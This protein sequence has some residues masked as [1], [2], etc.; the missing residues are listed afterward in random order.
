VNYRE[1]A[2][3]VVRTVLNIAD[4]T[5]AEIVETERAFREAAAEALNLPFAIRGVWPDGRRGAEPL[6][7]VGDAIKAG[8]VPDGVLNAPEAQRIREGGD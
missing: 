7:G 1:K 8:F 6:S 5:E 3:H 4:P 2:E